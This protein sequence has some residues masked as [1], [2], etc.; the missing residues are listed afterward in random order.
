MGMT[1][2][3]GDWLLGRDKRG[4]HHVI[5]ANNNNRDHVMKA[6]FGV[7]SRDIYP[8]ITEGFFPRTTASVAR[9]S[10]LT[11]SRLNFVPPAF[12]LYI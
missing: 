11:Q 10:S 2:F 5:D 8:D 7:A 3:P 1:F 12:S 6:K 4:F 9:L